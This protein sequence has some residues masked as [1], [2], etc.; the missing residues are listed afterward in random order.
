MKKYL[1]I[2]LFGFL[3]FF[4]SSCDDNTN[5]P[6]E[7]VVETGSV[8]LQSS[9]TGAT[10]YVDGVNKT[11]VTN[12]SITGLSV[13]NHTIK[14][15]LEGYYDTTFTVNVVKNM[16][17]R[18]SSITLKTNVNVV[19]FGPIRIWETTGTNNSQPSGL[20]LSAGLAKSLSDAD[21][22]I[23]YYSTSSATVFE[24]RSAHQSS[25]TKKKTYFKVGTGNNLL[26][27]IVAPTADANWGFNMPDRDSSKYY[28][29]YDQDKHYSKFKV[30]GWGGGTIGNPSY[31]DVQWIY[32][33][34]VDDKR[35]K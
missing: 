23:Y 21:I 18:P 7:P 1:V 5:D 20:D 6:V 22:D 8:F 35:F 34:T 32:N 4:L 17:T 28:F 24:I 27:G 29:L 3:G 12:D 2:F 13:G 15:V 14:L 11:K 19:T 9:P 31:V 16:Q 25:S 30:V 10:I 26:D 33:K